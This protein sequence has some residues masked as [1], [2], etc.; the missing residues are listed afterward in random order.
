MVCVLALKKMVRD[1]EMA[2]ALHS[3]HLERDCH[4]SSVYV[5]SDRYSR[6]WDTGRKKAGRQIVM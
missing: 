5:T 4:S 2:L 1:D 3:R 6:F